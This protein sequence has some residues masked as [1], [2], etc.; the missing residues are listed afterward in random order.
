[1]D[2]QN[3]TQKDDL[4]SAARMMGRKGGTNRAL[5]QSKNKLSQIGYLGGKASA[6]AK[7]K[8]RKPKPKPE[9]T[10]NGDG[11]EPSEP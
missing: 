5:K 2:E 9:E 10:K 4:S 8:K 11:S 7:A 3:E 6:K 1:M